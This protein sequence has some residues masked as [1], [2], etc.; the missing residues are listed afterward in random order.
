VLT[1]VG[2]KPRCGA[3]GGEDALR[4]RLDL[5]ALSEAREIESRATL[6]FVEWNENAAG[7]LLHRMNT[8]THPSLLV[9]DELGY[10][11]G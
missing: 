7:K 3:V 6:G 9:V 10:L 8:P 11:P 5:S 1:I 2:S 4:F